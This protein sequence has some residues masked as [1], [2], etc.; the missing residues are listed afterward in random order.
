[1]KRFT[2]LLLWTFITIPFYV[3]GAGIER[4]E[5][6]TPTLSLELSD[7][8]R[9]GKALEDLG[10]SRDD[11]WSGVYYAA[12]N[13]LIITG[14]VHSEDFAEM[15][16]I[17]ELF[18]LNLEGATIEGNKIPAQSFGFDDPV[19][20]PF[21]NE[22]LEEVLLP[23]TIRTIENEAFI[24]CSNLRSINLDQLL[25]LS[26]IGSMAFKA[27]RSLKTVDIPS[28]VVS[29]G[30][31]A[32]ADC[33]S[34]SAINV[35]PENPKFI[36]NDGVFYERSPMRAIVY[37][38]AKSAQEVVILEG[39]EEIADNFMV[40]R[41]DLETLI[42][43]NSLKR[44]GASAFARCFNLQNVT[45]GESLEIIDRESFF[46]TKIKSIVFP[47][48]LKEIGVGAF[49]R[50]ASLEDISLP[51]SLELLYSTA[52]ANCTSLKSVV[53]PL[54][55]NIK[56]L[57]A[58]IFRDC[59]SLE[60]IDLSSLTS[61]TVIDE[62]AFQRCE[63]LSEA[64]LP[65]SIKHIY[66][67][68]FEGCKVLKSIDL[69][70]VETLSEKAF[71][72]CESLTSIHIPE[73]LIS[74]GESVFAGCIGV[75]SITVDENNWNFA[76]EDGILYNS[77]ETGKHIVFVPVNNLVENIT[78]AAEVEEIPNYAFEGNQNIK[79]ITFLG[80][81]AKIGTSA[82]SGCTNLTS[83]VDKKGFEKLDRIGDAA[84]KDCPNFVGLDLTNATNLT[85]IGTSAFSN[86]SSI[87]SFDLSNTKV[88]EI[89][90]N[91]LSGCLNINELKFS[92]VTNGFGH[93]M[94]DGCALL[95]EVT[96]PASIIYISKI[97][98]QAFIG[99]GITTINVDP[100]STILQG[101]GS[102]VLTNN[103]TQLFMVAPAISGSLEIPEGVTSISTS[104][105]ICKPE[106]ETIV[107]PASYT[108][109]SNVFSS[110]LSLKSFE[111]AEGNTQYSSK[112][113]LLLNYAGDK[114]MALPMNIGVEYQM[115]EGPK[116]IASNSISQNTIVEMLTLAPG[117]ESI[118][119]NGISGCTSLK[120]MTIP[121]GFKTFADRAVMSCSNL[122]EVTILAR[123]VPQVSN[124]S[125][126]W[127]MGAGM[128]FFVPEDMI[129]LYKAESA[130]DVYN[131]QPIGSV[132]NPEIKND[133]FN[134]YADNGTIV[135][136]TLVEGA[137]A[138]LFD[139][140]G[141]V[142]GSRVINGSRVQ[143]SVP[144]RSSV[145]FVTIRVASEQVFVKKLAL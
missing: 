126:G 16:K 125:F 9:L 108:G 103:A 90:P 24:A 70:G 41:Q 31:F 49:A 119:A 104:A 53:F 102:T 140:N 143:M 2:L 55:S 93:S 66:N 64:L 26:T 23:T 5:S 25:D 75:E 35:S 107:L 62:F 97:N 54:S 19:L 81:V 138:T 42:L 73:S 30:S 34:L 18:V 48:T 96:I 144:S 68:A 43:P 37:P 1:M 98:S 63:N 20:A 8:L 77:N 135:V 74:V 114:L 65:E 13:E 44:V 72:N 57:E 76:V 21:G 117:L 82:F 109:F 36:S 52:F 129:D 124:Y 137:T 39:T 80:D 113:G 94:V 132:S 78:L 10:Y 29:I 46:S 92:S 86:C 100:L 111:V 50:C 69:K 123:E 85:Y 67:G 4:S 3:F 51:S 14:K 134:V 40:Y 106:I 22:Y 32:F 59:L 45:L 91:I 130:W 122:K 116:V 79:T 95:T 128:T 11:P 127:S 87:S 115:P 105:F 7:E 15:N 58:N 27:C 131:V 89:A 110:L 17:Q 142:I 145:V 99:S 139:I 47:S 33:N 60:K 121:E 38:M 141:Q 28:K 88:E 118:E 101:G 71:L 61:L 12:I 6:V 136:E 83:F 84:F 120:S 133:E 112:D 56:E